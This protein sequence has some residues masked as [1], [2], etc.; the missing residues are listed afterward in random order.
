MNTNN[1]Q[2]K[3]Y[4]NRYCAIMEKVTKEEKEYNNLKKDLPIKLKLY[5]ILFK[6]ILGKFRQETKLLK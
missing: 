6:P 2:I 1:S 4:Y 5:G 3:G